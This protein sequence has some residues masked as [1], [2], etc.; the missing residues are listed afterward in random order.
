MSKNSRY[1]NNAGTN[2]LNDL[3][4]LDNVELYKLYG[5]TIENC[6]IIDSINGRNFVNF[7]EFIDAYLADDY[8][9]SFEKFNGK[10]AFDDY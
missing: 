1:T 5:I 8:E 10:F 4:T 7:D 6:I 3:N 2:V 9:E